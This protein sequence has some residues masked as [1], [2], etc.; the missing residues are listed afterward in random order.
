MK[1]A[2]HIFY[3]SFSVIEF[4]YHE[5]H[6]FKTYNSVV[7]HIFTTLCNHYPIPEEHFYL[8]LK[9]F[10]TDLQPLLISPTPA[11]GNHSSTFHLY[12][13]KLYLWIYLSFP[14]GFA[15]YILK[16]FYYIFNNL[17]LLCP[18]AELTWFIIMK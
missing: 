16:L 10:H 18:F 4:A 8:P 14:L 6:P 1:K 17:G 12:G 11:P 5:M 13:F 2:D 3:N 9:E 15:S 7:F